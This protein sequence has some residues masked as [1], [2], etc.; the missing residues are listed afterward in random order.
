MR[1]LGWMQLVWMLSGCAVHHDLLAGE[2]LARQGDWP[3]AYATY[4]EAQ[5][6]HPRSELVQERVV[7]ARKAAREVWLSRA[8]I[9]IE[10]GEWDAARQ[11]LAAC[12]EIAPEDPRL[13]ELE[14]R[15]PSAQVAEVRSLAEFGQVELAWREAV[16]LHQADPAHPGARKLRE[17]M[18]GLVVKEAYQLYDQG[19]PQAAAAHL[20]I[21]LEAEPALAPA[22]EAK[23]GELKQ[24]WAASLRRRWAREEE[25]GDAVMAWA[26]ASVAAWLALDPRDVEARE[27]L[28]QG[29]E[30]ANGAGVWLQVDGP[31][32]ESRHWEAELTR[33][34]SGPSLVNRVRTREGADLAGLVEVAPPQ[35]VDTPGP[36]EPRTV[37]ISRGA[38]IV[39]NPTWSRRQQELAR[40]EAELEAL[41]QGRVD[42]PALEEARREAREAFDALPALRERE[43]AARAQVDVD[44]AAWEAASSAMIAGQERAQR[45]REALRRLEQTSRPD[46]NRLLAVQESITVARAALAE[47]PRTLTRARTVQ[48]TVDVAQWTRACE[49]AV[50]VTLDGAEP[51]V[52]SEVLELADSTHPALVA[53]GLDEDPLEFELTPSEFAARAEGALMVQVQKLLGNALDDERQRRLAGADGAG[54]ERLA[55]LLSAWLL[56]PTWVPE[57]LDDALEAEFGWR[58]HEAFLEAGPTARR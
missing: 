49:L 26:A 55:A 29:F 15:I 37:E 5:R 44:S 57:G 53:A 16:A 39:D 36:V 35:C 24:A 41:R 8:V 46:E 47:T 13:G 34:L 1:A 56:E 3:G 54:S 11:A 45:A 25:K 23:I 51:V 28:R 2:Q 4:R 22:V 10:A 18:R 14:R 42:S 32:G 43:F 52:L 40:R 33:A 38:E 17:E 19:R 21:L 30:L 7:L 9:A 50:T 58:A 12:R 20:Q 6:R 48:A 27:R 31:R